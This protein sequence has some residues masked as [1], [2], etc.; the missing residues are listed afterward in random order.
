LL[1]TSLAIFKITY[2]ILND[3][4][5]SITHVISLIIL[6]FFLGYFNIDKTIVVEK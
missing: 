6:F 4:S 3:V 5:L 2:D 1:I